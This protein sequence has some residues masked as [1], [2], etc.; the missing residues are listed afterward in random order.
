MVA[1]W[2]KVEADE[3]LIEAGIET[4]KLPDEITQIEWASIE[5]ANQ[6]MSYYSGGVDKLLKNHTLYSNQGTI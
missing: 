5:T 4:I 2:W 1:T 3:T 6:R